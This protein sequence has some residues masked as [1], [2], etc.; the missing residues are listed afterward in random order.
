[1]GLTVTKEKLNTSLIRAN[2]YWALIAPIFLAVIMNFIP[3]QGLFIFKDLLFYFSL[4]AIFS[5]GKSKGYLLFLIR[6]FLFITFLFIL[7]FFFDGFKGWMV[8]NLRQLIVP[9]L[10]V[11]FGY[12]SYVSH[13]S[14]NQLVHAYYKSAVFIVLIGIIIIQFD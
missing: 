10:I 7:T 14:F 13:E 3:R 8:Y 11:S 12:Y 1:M 4:V 6:L 5:M 2:V 9:V